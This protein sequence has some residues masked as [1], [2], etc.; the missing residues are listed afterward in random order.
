M[1]ALSEWRGGVDW[2]WISAVNTD[3]DIA[4]L[5]KPYILKQQPQSSRPEMPVTA[6]GA[7]LHADGQAH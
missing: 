4:T 3:F 2:R 7:R 6:A 5:R 1:T